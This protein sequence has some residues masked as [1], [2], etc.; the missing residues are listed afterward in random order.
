MSSPDPSPNSLLDHFR[1]KVLQHPKEGKAATAK[2][3]DRKPLDPPPIVQLT[4]D[5]APNSRYRGLLTPDFPWTMCVARLEDAEE[6]NASGR[7]NQKSTSSASSTLI[8]NIASSVHKA[9][10]GDDD[11]KR[12]VGVLVFPN[13]SVRNKGRFRL[14][15]TAY[16]MPPS[17][18]GGKLEEEWVAVA[19]TTSE[20]FNVLEG[21]AYPGLAESTSLTR[22]LADQG[23]KLRLHRE[24]AARRTKNHN[25]AFAESQDGR[26]GGMGGKRQ[27]LSGDSS[28]ATIPSSR[29]KQRPLTDQYNREPSLGQTHTPSNHMGIGQPMLAS[30]STSAYSYAPTSMAQSQ[31]MTFAPNFPYHTMAGQSGQ[32]MVPS[33]SSSFGYFSWGGPTV[34]SPGVVASQMP[35]VSLPSNP[36]FGQN[37]PSDLPFD[38]RLNE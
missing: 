25:Q 2:D 12:E 22:T 28:I 7:T 16:I 4:V 1:L 17:P 31:G 23:I 37:I 38:P 8:G 15:F 35:P 11:D 36:Q 33:H 18:D 13:L 19:E 26:G 20:V 34:G 29:G 6:D 27:R 3:K 9:K 5:A 14:H 32:S 21:R 30:Q 24:S 10:I